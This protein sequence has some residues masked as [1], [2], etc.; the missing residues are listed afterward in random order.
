MLC[1]HGWITGVTGP[2]HNTAPDR[3]NKG[4]DVGGTDTANKGSDG[5][6]TD[7]ANKTKIWSANVGKLRSIFSQRDFNNLNIEM[8]EA[9][10]TAYRTVY[11]HTT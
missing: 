7:T 8:A 3:C 1:I 11:V 9:A 4:S 6:G 10:P 5:G 2:I